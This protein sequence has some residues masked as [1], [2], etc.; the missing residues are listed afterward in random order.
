MKQYDLAVFIGRFQPFHWAHYEV[1]KHA[2]TKADRVLVLIGSANQPRDI[3]NPFTYEE[4]R[5]IIMKCFDEDWIRIK[6]APLEDC[7]YNDAAWVNQVQQH[8]KQVCASDNLT[9][10]ALIGHDKED[11]TG[12][13]LKLFPQWDSISVGLRREGANSTEIRQ[14]YFTA[15]MNRSYRDIAP[16]ATVSFMG[17][18]MSTPAYDA[19]VKE[20]EFKLEHDRK[21]WVN[22]KYH[23]QLKEGKRPLGIP[24]PATFQT[25]DAVVVQSAHILLVKRKEHPGKGTWALPGGYVNP[26]ETL[27]DGTFRELYEETKIKVPEAVLRGSI[28]ASQTFDDP[29]R[30]PRGRVITHA[31][32]FHLKPDLKLPKVKGSDDAEVAKWWALSDISRPMMFED[33]MDI[34]IN[35]V[36]RL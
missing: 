2:L 29:T 28:V 15:G 1:I 13:Y 16:P 9:S 14:M 18:F 3:R 8:V 34:I 32:L 19:L 7:R 21:W 20:Y 36:S 5:S 31:T 4:R 17:Q 11:G 25:V 27:L 23:E 10:V 35:M 33:H 30:S 12:Y 6:T 26:R 24:F 22:P